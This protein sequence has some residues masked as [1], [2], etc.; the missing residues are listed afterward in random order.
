MIEIDNLRNLLLERK[1]VLQLEAGD[2][3]DKGISI[4]LLDDEIK[5]ATDALEKEETSPPTLLINQ[6]RS[7]QAEV[8]QYS[9]LLAYLDCLYLLMDAPASVA[10]LVSIN[11]LLSRIP[12]MLELHTFASVLA[13]R[14]HT[15]LMD[16]LCLC[17]DS[18]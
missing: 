7:L 9:S 12:P 13:V 4:F 8:T 3:H 5:A 16:D 11:E 2:R 6:L 10:G 14:T 1:S 18:F 17:V 15:T